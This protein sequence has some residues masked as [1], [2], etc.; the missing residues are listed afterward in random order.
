MPGNDVQDQV[1][2]TD[3]IQG[4][5]YN[6]TFI[7]LSFLSPSMTTYPLNHSVYSYMLNLSLDFLVGYDR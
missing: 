1:W 7:D 4:E 3:N 6:T 5:K 2:I